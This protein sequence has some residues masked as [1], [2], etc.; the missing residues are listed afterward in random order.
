[1][2]RELI[3]IFHILEQGH[4][5]INHNDQVYSGLKPWCP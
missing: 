5:V 3:L 4:M 1:M 2:L